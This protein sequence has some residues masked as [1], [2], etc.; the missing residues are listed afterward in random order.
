MFILKNFLTNLWRLGKFK[1]CSVGRQT[2]DPGK[3]CSLSPKAVCWQNFFL[4]GEVSLFLLRPLTSWM[5]PT[6]IIKDNLLYSK[7]TDLDV[8]LILK[9]P[10]ET[11]RIMFDQI[12][13]YC[14]PAKWTHKINHHAYNEILFSHK[15]G[16]STDSCYN[17]DEPG[18]R[19]TKWKKSD[20]KP[21][22]FCD[23]IYVKYPE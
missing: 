4:L 18:K 21:H 9:I 3:S 13:G 20:T 19:F 22:I 11:Y 16:P 1:I 12:P 8:N 10:P 7:S 5:R 14:G 2:G 15:K 17:M 6:Y 23:S